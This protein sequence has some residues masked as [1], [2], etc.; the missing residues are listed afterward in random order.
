MIREHVKLLVCLLLAIAPFSSI[1]PAGAAGEDIWTTNGPYGL[2]LFELIIDHQ[3]PNILYAFSIDCV[4][5]GIP[6]VVFKSTNAGV[7]WFPSGSGIPLTDCGNPRWDGMVMDPEDSDILYVANDEGIYKTT[8]GGQSWIQVTPMRTLSLALT[9]HGEIFAGVYD[10]NDFKGSIYHSMDGGAT[11]EPSDAGLPPQ[12]DVASTLAVAPNA[13]HIIYAGFQVGG[14]YKSLDGGHT[15]ESI[16]NGFFTTPY[17]NL[18]TVDPYD[19][20]V[21]YFAAGSSLVLFRSN[22]GGASWNP[23]GEGLPSQPF[24]LIIDPGNQQVIY[25]ATANG[26]YRSLDNQGSS[27]S[28]LSEGL[29]NRLVN[30]LAIDHQDPQNMYAGTTAGIWKRTLVFNEPEDYSVSIDAAALYTSD[31]QV[32]LSF[33]APAGTSQVMVSNDGGFGGAAWEAYQKTKPWT[34]TTYGQYVLPRTVY[35]KFKNSGKITGLYQDDIIYDPNAP[36]GSVVIT[37]TVASRGDFF[38]L[39]VEPALPRVD[40]TL[41][42]PVT[43]W[44][45]RPGYQLLHLLISAEDDLSGLNGMMISDNP[46]FS[47]AQWE[48]YEAHRELWAPDNTHMTIYVKFRDRAGNES[49]IISPSYRSE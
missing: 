10:E 2:R 37:N 38:R 30:S 11:W 16:N 25:A 7:D 20:Q 36:S 4:N 26:V 22:N 14:L 34:I 18:I 12:P 3:N 28:P 24:S 42:L 17:A 5:V 46:D 35:V 44:R 41:Y 6:A 48:P 39:T 33:T 49:E 43:L 19:S 27:W 23:I 15:W 32:V 21:V 29:G 31:T 9:P 1:W 47:D 13:Q 8:D 40:T 45:G